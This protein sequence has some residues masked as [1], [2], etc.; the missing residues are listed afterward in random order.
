MT[1]TDH[2]EP[3][4]RLRL[5]GEQLDAIDPDPEKRFYVDWDEYDEFVRLDDVRAILAARALPDAETLDVE[6][7]ARAMD[8][9]D[10]DV[11]SGGDYD[12]EL[13][14]EHREFAEAIAAEYAR[15]RAADAGKEPHATAPSSEADVARATTAAAALARPETMTSAEP[16]P[17]TNEGRAMLDRLVPGPGTHE[18]QCATCL[19]LNAEE[20]AEEAA[21][22]I[23]VETEAIGRARAARATPALDLHAIREEVRQAVIEGDASDCS[24]PDCIADAV[25]EIVRSHVRA[26]DAGREPSD[27]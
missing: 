19:A 9:A 15:L 2:P 11:I 10:P 23:E 22:I 14:Q 27:D 5:T 8:A 21:R 3:L 20:R 6:A 26:A 17:M 7:L 12:E 4:P 13:H 16:L 24:S 25:Y 1:T 18:A